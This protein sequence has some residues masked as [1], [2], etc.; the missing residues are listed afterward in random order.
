MHMHTA[1]A[2][3]QT[4]VKEVREVSRRMQESV[5]DGRTLEV[6]TTNMQTSTTT[7]TTIT[8]SR[9]NKN[10]ALSY[11]H[12]HDHCHQQHRPSHQ[13]TITINAPARWWRQ[14]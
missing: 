3:V 14:N 5:G 6:Y 2:R 4:K 13:R 1:H 12:H 10:S 8:A 7:T 9:D 11:H